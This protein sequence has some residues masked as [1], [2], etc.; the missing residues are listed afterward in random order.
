MIWLL[1]TPFVMAACVIAMRM[2]IRKDFGLCIFFGCFFGFF[3][4]LLFLITPATIV[5]IGNT[6]E[7]VP[8]QSYALVALK[9]RDGIY[10]RFFLGSGTIEGSQYYFWYRKTQDGGI[11]G[12]RTYRDPSVAI[13]EITDGSQPR[14]QTYRW[15]DPTWWQYWFTID[16]SG[17]I[18]DISPIFY[19]PKGSIQEGYAL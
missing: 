13:R 4:S 9:E 11:Q 19:I 17:P 16:Q 14:M 8:D 3:S 18:Q 15:A 1:L 6:Y 5:G 12:G 2:K 10:G 7:I